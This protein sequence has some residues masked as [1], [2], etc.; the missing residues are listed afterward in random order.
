MTGR[1]V[2]GRARSAQVNTALGVLLFLTAATGVASWLV[3]TGAA[4]PLTLAHAIGGIGLLL[5]TRAKTRGPVR[6]GLRSGRATRWVS[7]VFGVAVL[8]NWYFR[9]REAL[10]T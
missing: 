4:R 1:A 6:T 7:V 2:T 8:A 10:L 3:A 5:L 9:R